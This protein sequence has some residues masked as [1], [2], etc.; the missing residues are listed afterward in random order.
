MKFNMSRAITF[1]RHGICETTKECRIDY[2]WLPLG[3]RTSE[4][5]MQARHY[6]TL[7]FSK[8]KKYQNLKKDENIPNI[9]TEN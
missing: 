1:V 8:K 7:G 2:L 5:G 9:N 4:P 3:S 6:F